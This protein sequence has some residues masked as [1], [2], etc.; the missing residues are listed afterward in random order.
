MARRQQKQT[1]HEEAEETRRTILRTAQTLFMEFGYRAVSTRQIADACGL[2][3]PAL[4]HYFADK[5]AL[6]AAVMSENLTEI[7]SALERISRRGESVQ[8]RLQQ[9]ARYLLRNVQNDH[10]LMFHDIRYE[11]DAAVQDKLSET[12]R[13]RMIAPIAAIFEDGLQQHILRDQAQGGV[14]SV[15]ATY[16]F[17]N[18]LTRFLPRGPRQQPVPSTSRSSIVEQAETIVHILLYGLANAEEETLKRL[19]SPCMQNIDPANSH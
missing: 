12:F 5:K 9:V 17:L 7:G 15:T 1:S 10:N 13:V 6:Y 2:T 16:I 19:E 11:M 8:E 3:Q 4:Y 14:D 18:V